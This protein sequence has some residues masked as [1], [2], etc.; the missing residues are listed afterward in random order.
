MCVHHK[1]VTAY[2]YCPWLLGPLHNQQ[3][4]D[5]ALEEATAKEYDKYLNENDAAETFLQS[6]DD[7]EM[8]D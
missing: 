1:H 5:Y 6:C 4:I 8:I 2:V 3:V 7:I